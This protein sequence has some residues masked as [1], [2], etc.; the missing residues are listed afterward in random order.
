MDKSLAPVIALAE[1]RRAP[2]PPD[3]TPVLPPGASPTVR[4]AH[5]LGLSE[6]ARVEREWWIETL[7]PWARQMWANAHPDMAGAVL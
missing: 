6:G 7:G 2:Q 4:Q 3:S 5:S 1:R